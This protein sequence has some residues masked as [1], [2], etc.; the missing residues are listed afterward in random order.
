MDDDLLT[1]RRVLHSGPPTPQATARARDLLTV[2]IA[3]AAAERPVAARRPTGADP[4]PGMGRRGPSSHIRLGALLTGGLAAAIVAAVVAV[5]ALNGPDHDGRGA[6][7]G[8]EAG[9]APATAQELLLAAAQRAATAPAATGKY[10]HTRKM[11]TAGVIRVGSYDLMGRWLNETWIPGDASVSSWSGDL[12]LGYKPRTRADEE[13]WRADGSPTSWTVKAD[14]T[15]GTTTFTM[16][17]GEPILREEKRPVDKPFLP[18][19]G[20][21]TMAEIAALPTDPAALRARVERG[22]RGIAPA[23][24]DR[25]VYWQLGQLLLESPAPPAVRAAAFTAM[26]GIPGVRSAGTVTDASG[27]TGTGVELV[28]THEDG[29]TSRHLVVIDPKTYGVIATENSGTPGGAAKPIKE[30]N[31][32]VLLAEWT[33]TE[34]T[35]PTVP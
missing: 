17:P 10:W 35:P 1:I 16:A 30:S 3:T 26:A 24:V 13:A 28:I 33:N 5:P 32:V 27:R 20:G 34:P 19:I 21:L 23:D 9:P 4:V 12:M 7:P 11:T 29:L 14:T 18:A 25:T 6:P 15:S 31:T 22:L 2:E 8:A